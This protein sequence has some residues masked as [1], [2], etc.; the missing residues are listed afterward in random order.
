M[1]HIECTVYRYGCRAHLILNELPLADT[2][3][4]PLTHILI[5]TNTSSFPVPYVRIV[6]NN[7][8]KT[9]NFFA[10]VVAHIIYFYVLWIITKN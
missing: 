9:F 4:F 8:F 7:L 5:F 3:P 10:V 2:I 1:I 6:R